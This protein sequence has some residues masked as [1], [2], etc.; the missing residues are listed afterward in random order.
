MNT[1]F[2]GRALY[3]GTDNPMTGLHH[4]KG[5][6]IRTQKMKSGKYRVTVLDTPLSPI[7]L[8]YNDK[9]ECGF[10]WKPVKNN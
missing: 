2:E 9:K 10:T 5:Y 4:G 7:R 3:C 6:E 1:V 8:N